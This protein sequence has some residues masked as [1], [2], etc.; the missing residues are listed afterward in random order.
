M[1]PPPLM[2]ATAGWSWAG[3]N[4][5]APAGGVAAPAGGATG[6]A[7]VLKPAAPGSGAGGAGGGIFARDKPTSSARD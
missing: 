1:A 3:L 5:G 6:A 4:G 2:P 7:G